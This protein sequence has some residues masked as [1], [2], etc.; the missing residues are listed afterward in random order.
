VY[1][2]EHPSLAGTRKVIGGRNF[3]RSR[4]KVGG[5]GR[6]TAWDR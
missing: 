1:S 2:S 5:A 6:L 3:Q 4:E